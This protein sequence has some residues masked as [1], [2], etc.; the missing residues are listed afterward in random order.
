[1]RTTFLLST[2]LITLL[3]SV[4]A[5]A[6]FDGPLPVRNQ[7][8]LFLGIDPPF[9]DTAEPMDAFSIGL[10][11]SS[12][13][14]L[15]RS[16]SWQV[17]ID[18]EMTELDLRLKKRL[19]DRTEVGLDLPVIR[20]TGGFFDGPLDA[21][22]SLFP[23]GDY[24]RHNRPENAFVYEILYQGAPV[25]VGENDRT[26]L[27]DVRLTGKRVLVEGSTVLSLQVNVEFPTGDAKAGYGNG[28]YDAAV[29]LLAD[30]RWSDTYRGYANAGWIFP[31]DL[32][33]YQTVPLR[34]VPFGG[35]SVEA[36]W[37]DHVSIIAQTVVQRSPLPETGI[38][39][40]DLPGVLFTVGGRYH[41]GAGALELS[42]TEDP[43][44]SG[45]PD[46]IASVSWMRRLD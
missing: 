20:P 40:V 41:G 35:F 23:F 15:E 25:I 12:T 9:L 7:F 6:G 2:V 42:L 26:A 28:S 14:M 24:G 19:D 16:P 31:G 18:I 3:S 5:A 33:G 46:F 22:H 39:H 44:V 45:A 34:P 37:W 8:P 27:G 30:F 1:M 4:A 43:N 21:W 17:S 32:K 38:E 10:H 36:A 29:A 13:Y 11:H